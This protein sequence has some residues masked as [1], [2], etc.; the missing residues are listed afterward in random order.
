MRAGAAPRSRLLSDRLRR[1][2]D[3]PRSLARCAAVAIRVVPG[4]SL[5]VFWLLSRR[6]SY[7]RRLHASRRNQRPTPHSR[8]PVFMWPSL[9]GLGCPL[10]F[11]EM[12]TADSLGETQSKHDDR[13]E[14]EQATKQM[15]ATL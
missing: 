4:Q 10:R 5:A 2:R 1:S 12:K 13:T 3:A 11:V 15:R 6:C 8:L 7:R 9:A 14:V